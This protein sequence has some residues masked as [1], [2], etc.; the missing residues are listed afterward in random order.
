M[1]LAS[2]ESEVITLVGD[3]CYLFGVPGSAFWVAGACG[4]ATLTVV[5]NNGG[6]K[7]PRASTALV[8][9][10]GPAERHDTYWVGSGRGVKFEAWP[11][12]RAARSASPCRTGPNW[13][14]RCA[15]LAAVRG[16]AAPW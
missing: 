11:R 5:Y 13:R 7:S 9:P 1:K 10:D 12:P 6:W 16:G 14:R 4:A 3:G 2:P 8:H 15:R